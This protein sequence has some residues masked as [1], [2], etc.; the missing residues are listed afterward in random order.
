[1][2]NPSKIL[3]SHFFSFDG[4]KGVGKSTLIQKVGLTLK[5]KGYPVRILIEKELDP[6]RE[7]TRAVLRD[8]T[9]NPSIEKERLVLR[10]LTKG[11]V[12]ISQNIL[13]LDKPMI[14]LIDRWYPS[15]A[16][17]RRY[18][19]GETCINYNLEQGVVEPDGVFAMYC[20]PHIS[21]SRAHQRTEGLHSDVIR[22]HSDHALSTFRF[23]NVAKKQNW[24]LV[25][26]APTQ[27]ILL[28][29]VWDVIQTQISNKEASS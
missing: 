28:T 17:F 3:M 21:F 4:P 2:A 14:T 29:T 15:D 27:D 7:E 22:T 1:M 6:Y 10:Q 11:R 18:I 12:W 24:I 5:M 19:S 13:P 26:T 25:D 16:V 23:V 20:E 9:K 8:F